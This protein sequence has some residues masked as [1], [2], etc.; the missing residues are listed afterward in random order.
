M[1][2]KDIKNGWLNHFKDILGTLDPAIKE[3]AESRLSIC[4]DCPMRTNFVCDPLKKGEAVKNFKYGQEN[5]KKG[6]LY[7]GC[8]C[9]LE[10][11]TKS[12][13]A[14]CPLGKW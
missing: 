4:H 9:P 3:L 14:I 13:E 6:Q 7:R 8:G 2:L 5:R 10:T 11:K 12:E 1:N